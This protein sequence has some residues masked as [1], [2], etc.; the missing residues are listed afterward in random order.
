M[1]TYVTSLKELSVLAFFLDITHFPGLP[2]L[3]GINEEEA[4]FLTNNMNKEGM[5]I[6]RG[7]NCSV[8]LALGFILKQLA[9]PKL[10]VIFNDG[11]FA[12]CNN[13]L[14]SVVKVDNKNKNKFKI[15]PLPTPEDM[16]EFFWEKDK[17][18]EKEVL[19]LI[20]DTDSTK[21]LVSKEE[22]VQLLSVI[23]TAD[24]GFGGEK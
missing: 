22:L 2:D 11:S 16:A 8:D 18:G 4:A 1:I 19:H 17:L 12:T 7:N 15:T 3:P 20:S 5:L 13:R 21:I 24:H 23:Y 10:I 9:N 6:I 14:G